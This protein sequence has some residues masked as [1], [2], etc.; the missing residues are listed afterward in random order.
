MPAAFIPELDRAIFSESC[1][2]PATRH[3][4]LPFSIEAIQANVNKEP[5]L[6]FELFSSLYIALWQN[7]QDLGGEIVAHSRLQL[8]PELFAG[9]SS[10]TDFRKFRSGPLSDPDL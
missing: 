2:S 7:R 10:V 6:L 4:N 8:T 9:I 5:A 1:N 3:S